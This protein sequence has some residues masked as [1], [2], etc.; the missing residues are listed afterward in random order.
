MKKKYD[1]EIVLETNCDGGEGP[2]AGDPLEGFCGVSSAFNPRP[3]WKA[4]I[5]MRAMS[6]PPYD[7]DPDSPL[8]AQSSNHERSKK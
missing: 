7:K 8:P 2:D 5:G 6:I 1:V 4:S 3:G